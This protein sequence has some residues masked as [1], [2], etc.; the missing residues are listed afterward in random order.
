MIAYNKQWLYNVYVRNIAEES[1]QH[2]D[3]TI[4]EKDSILVKHPYLFYT[5]NIF[6][7]IGLFL[8]TC[9]ISILSIGLFSLPFISGDIEKTIAVLAIIVSLANYAAL[10]FFTGKKHHFNSGVDHALMLITATCLVSGINILSNVSPITNAFI[11]VIVAGY[12]AARFSD[13][14]MSVVAFCCLICSIIFAVITHLPGLKYYLPFI[15][16][17]ISIVSIVGIRKLNRIT[18]YR[19]HYYS[20]LLWLEITA[21][22]GLYVFG[23]YYVVKEPG[24]SL[25]NPQS[26]G[27]PIPFAFI[28]W[29]LTMVIP[30]GYLVYGIIKK[31]ILYIRLGLVCIVAMAVTIRHYYNL[32]AAEIIL[33]LGGVILTGIAWILIRYLKQA[34]KGYSSLKLYNTK[35]QVNLESLVV[36]ETFG[37]N[38]ASHDDP[39]FGGGSGG[40]GGASSDY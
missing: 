9:L 38:S 18:Y 32:L 14:F 5:P 39:F 26:K 12:F 29:I 10:E 15:L 3:I 24:N 19:Q 13:A 21:A 2:G 27:S 33:T 22:I 4:T 25:L 35:D 7:R 31:K 20:S 11:G 34:R 16:I 36:I 6:I 28:F 8:L 37:H 1:Y 30:L 40:G 23:N 17:T